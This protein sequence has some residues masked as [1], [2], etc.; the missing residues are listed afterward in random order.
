MSD[1]SSN[2]SPTN[3]GG[4]VPPPPNFNGSKPGNNGRR[5][6]P[7]WLRQEQADFTPGAKLPP[8]EIIFSLFAKRT[9]VFVLV[10]LLVIF[11]LQIAEALPP[12]VWAIVTAYVL[13]RPMS[14]LVRR[15]RLAAL[16]LDD[17]LLPGVFRGYRVGFGVNRAKYLA[18]SSPTNPGR[19]Q[20]QG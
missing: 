14:M 13:N 4:N 6:Q 8:H 11:L 18:R 7:D 16:E 15:T 5:G 20:N 10:G 3:N 9:T 12:F 2:I 19:A 1:N 17:N